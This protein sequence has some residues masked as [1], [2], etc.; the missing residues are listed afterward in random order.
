[1]DVKVLTLPLNLGHTT[2]AQAAPHREHSSILHSR[3]LRSPL[4]SLVIP[5]LKSMSTHVIARID[6]GTAA[7]SRGWCW[8]RV[9]PARAN[10][11][12]PHAGLKQSLCG[13]L[14]PTRTLS[15]TSPRRQAVL[16]RVVI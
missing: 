14:W 7:Q 13:C 12:R 2:I 4:S 1:M 3:L 6:S 15:I 8:G 16:W 11:Q 9:Y 10:W 5:Q